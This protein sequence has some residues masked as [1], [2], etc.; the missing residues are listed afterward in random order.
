MSSKKTRKSKKSSKNNQN[1]KHKSKILNIFLLIFLF[2]FLAS[3][4]SYFIMQNQ[5]SVN[6]SIKV[7]KNTFE[8]YTKEFEKDYI[9]PDPKIPVEDKSKK[10]IEAK[11]TL[12][13]KDN[14]PKIAIIIDDVSTKRDKQRI[15]DIGYKINMA[16]LPPTNR[17]KN[18]AKI[19]Q[20]VPF[21]IIHFPMEASSSFNAQEEGALKI[22]DSYEQIEQKVKELRKLFPNATYTNNHTGS[23]FTQ[24]DEAM[25]KLFRALKKYE[26]IFVDSRTTSKSVAKKYAKKYDMPYIVRNIFID[27]KKDYEYIQNQLK[28]AIKIAK[29]RGYSIAIGHPDSLTLKVLKESAHLLEGLEPIFVN[30]LPYL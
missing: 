25:D 20:D 30:E 18:S 6:K 14:K 26:F 2:A 4:S 8:E 11:D 13:K 21:H 7:Q 3:I 23:V 29:D 5:T 19:A 15:L 22:S 12:D 10:N 9:K 17:H 27:N 24:N 28:K 16:F 1:L